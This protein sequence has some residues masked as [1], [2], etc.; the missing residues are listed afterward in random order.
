MPATPPSSLLTA[1][2]AFQA[3]A[4]HIPL[5]ATNPH[6]KSKFASLPSIMQIV[7]PK[8]SEHGLVWTTTPSQDEQG[9]P[10]LKYQLAHAPSGELVLSEMPLLLTKQDPQ[11]LGSAITYARRYAL[12]SVLGLVGD[13]DDDGNAASTPTKT[14]P[15]PLST[16]AVGRVLKAF[17][18][19]GVDSEQFDLYLSAVGL[20]APEKMTTDHA[21]AL[22]GLLDKHVAP[23]AA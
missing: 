8:L 17:E 23:V 10:T 7:R 11:S 20:E 5:D 19:A 14:E 18:E 3:D 13:A 4:P 1:L 22:K 9:R 21:K 16:E 2:L 12:L 15:Q 6:F